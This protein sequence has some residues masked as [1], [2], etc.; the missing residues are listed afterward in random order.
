MAPGLK[1]G[2]ADRLTWLV[3]WRPGV[4]GVTGVGGTGN[5]AVPRQSVPL[6]AQMC[7]H[8]ISSVVNAHIH[9]LQLLNGSTPKQDLLVSTW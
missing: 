4:W 1:R 2:A 3:P 7:N 6:L 9:L 5:A 8:L